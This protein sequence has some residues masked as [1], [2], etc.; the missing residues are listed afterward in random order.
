MHVPGEDDVGLVFLDPLGQLDVAIGPAAA[1][2]GRGLARRRVIDPDPR[3]L[4]AR[5]IALELLGDR[6]PLGRA[7]PPGADREEDAADRHRLPVAHHVR[8]RAHPAG[9]LLA[10]AGARIE[11]VVARADDQPRLRP[12]PGEVL[13]DD[14]DLGTGVDGRAE[15]EVVAGDDHHVEV[16]GDARQ[17][18]ELGQRI[19]QVRHDE[20]AH[21]KGSFQLS[22]RPCASATPDRRQGLRRLGEG[23]KTAHHS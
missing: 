5:G 9:D 22:P 11:V 19:M 1:P 15:V 6:R 10:V 21:R 12:E 3:L 13:A 14:H 7:V 4:L 23:L 8:H 17:P 20:E 18:V 16:R 2:A